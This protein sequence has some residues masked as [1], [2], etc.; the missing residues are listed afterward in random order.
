MGNLNEYEL[1]WIIG[2]NDENEL[3]EKLNDNLKKQVED[4]GGSIGTLEDY[5]KR[6]LAHIIEGQKEGNYFL[7]RFSLDS[8]KI[9]QV[10]DEIRRENKIIRHLLTKVDSKKPLLAASKMDDVPERNRRGK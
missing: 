7:S 6:T 4:A 5:G 3:S 1:M 10:E 2:S 8:S 9:S